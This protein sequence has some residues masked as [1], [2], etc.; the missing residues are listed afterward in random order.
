MANIIIFTCYY[1]LLCV[2]CFCVWSFELACPSLSISWL[3]L[4]PWTWA[5]ANGPYRLMAGPPGLSLTRTANPFRPR[6]GRRC[7]GHLSL[8]VF[9]RVDTMSV[10]LPVLLLLIAVVCSCCIGL[11]PFMSDMKWRLNLGKVWYITVF[12][13][14]LFWFK[15]SILPRL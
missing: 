2:C 9:F 5:Q 1:L 6:S 7:R 3:R 15:Y 13:C 10:G 8:L 12:S 14:V 4:L 11:A